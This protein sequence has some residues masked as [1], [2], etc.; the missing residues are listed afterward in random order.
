MPLTDETWDQLFP[1]QAK[2]LWGIA[3]Q[4]VDEPDRLLLF[5]DTLVE[6]QRDRA[7]F[8]GSTEASL[9][10]WLAS[11]LRRNFFD[12]LRKQGRR[13]PE[14]PLAELAGASSSDGALLALVGERVTRQQSRVE[15]LI[16]VTR[17]L[18]ALPEN[19]R[20]CVQLYLIEELTFPEI[21]ARLGRSEP[22]V[23]KACYRGFKRVRE[24][25]SGRSAA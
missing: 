8:Q 7:T 20:V 15:A 22:S 5:E 18:K 6:A 2:Y 4:L 25:L 17:A 23:K 12:L 10:S 19:E 9:R 24:Q 1:A 3:K 14:I 11:I 16:D 21:A 13:P